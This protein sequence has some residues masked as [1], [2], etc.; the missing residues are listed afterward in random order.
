MPPKSGGYYT[1]CI[2]WYRQG[3]LN[4]SAQLSPSGNFAEVDLLAPS[5]DVQVKTD[6]PTRDERIDNIAENNKQ[7]RYYH[8][9]SDM[10]R[11]S[12]F[13]RQYIRHLLC[14]DVCRNDIC[15]DMRLAK[16]KAKAKSRLGKCDKLKEALARFDEM[17]EQLILQLINNKVFM[18]AVKDG[19]GN[20]EAAL[21]EYLKVLDL[22]PEFSTKQMK[23]LLDT[24]DPSNGNWLC[25][26]RNMLNQ[27]CH[28]DS[29]RYTN[30]FGLITE[31]VYSEHNGN[32]YRTGENKLNAEAINECF[33]HNTALVTIP[34]P[35]AVKLLLAKP[36]FSDVELE[37]LPSKVAAACQE[38]S[39][40]PMY[41]LHP[42]WELNEIW[43]ADKN[44]TLEQLMRVFMCTATNDEGRMY[45]TYP[46]VN[47]FGFDGNMFRVLTDFVENHD[48][49]WRYDWQNVV[50]AFMNIINR[51]GHNPKA[52]S[53]D[54][55]LEYFNE[56]GHKYKEKCALK[57][58]FLVGIDYADIC[59]MIDDIKRVYQ[60][61][62]DVITG[63]QNIL[64]SSTDPDF[65]KW[66]LAESHISKQQAN[67]WFQED[68]SNDI[69]EENQS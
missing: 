39:L 18:D 66:L 23:Q 62:I 12:S 2:K 26:W 43:A 52:V 65:V 51:K 30:M 7:W 56:D 64:L 68:H 35:D 24:V 17:K 33:R 9:F 28:T 1:V 61:Q 40:C 48:R 15:N 4:I 31:P 34:T 59:N 22:F 67:T 37:T 46:G 13:V 45:P 50:I 41:Q 3:T 63:I 47:Y 36:E 69:T 57:T 55:V 16:L 49:Q 20:N 38:V 27:Y 53:L 60:Q 10:G 25:S 5:Y 19:Y 58:Y 32:R 54:D 8:A 29:E 42:Y 14:I 6:S 21:K 11:C 44:A